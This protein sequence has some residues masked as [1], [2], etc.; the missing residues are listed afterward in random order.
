[1]EG[2]YLEFGVFEGASFVPVFHFAQGVGLNSMKFYAFDSFQGLPS[3]KKTDVG[4]FNKGDWVC[5]LPKFKK[6]IRNRGVDLNKVKIVK[7]WFDET[8]NEET[9]RKLPIKSAS[10]V[11]IDCDLYEST[12]PV[13][14][15]I[16]DYLINGT[17][18]I[19]DDWF[20][21]K[22]NPNRGEQRAFKEWRKRHPEIT[23]IQFRKF[24]CS[25][26]SFIVG[27]KHEKL[28]EN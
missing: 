20:C 8:L 5:T 15:F 7:G 9:K 12:V 24:G 17:I 6:L 14:D 27:E 4:L 23:I 1:V 22:G 16:T 13:L 11:Y 3:V 25:G 21:F 26:N 18:I 10:I 19:F 2:D 28:K